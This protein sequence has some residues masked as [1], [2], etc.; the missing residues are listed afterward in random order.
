MKEDTPISDSIRHRRNAVIVSICVPVGM[1]HFVTGPGYIGPFADFVNGYL[2]DIL[3]PFAVYFLLA[4][5]RDKVRFFRPWWIAAGAVFLI[6]AAAE[7]AQYQGMP[8]LGRTFDPLDF[9]AY[10]AGVLLAAL[11]DRHLFTRVFSFWHS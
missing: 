11:V 4:N 8:I 2:I 7:I 3:L 9:V 6:G 10:A 5:V 1:L